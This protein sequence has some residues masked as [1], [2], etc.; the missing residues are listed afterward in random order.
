MTTEEG[1]SLQELTN[2]LQN[3]CHDGHSLDKVVI[4]IDGRGE[5]VS[6]F[7]VNRVTFIRGSKKKNVIRLT[8]WRRHGKTES[9]T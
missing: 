7:T 6:D 3:L 4:D 9:N 5:D 2:K 1:M 8:S